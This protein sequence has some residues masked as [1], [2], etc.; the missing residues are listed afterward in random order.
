MHR[1]QPACSRMYSWLLHTYFVFQLNSII[2]DPHTSNIY[3]VNKWVNEW[4][5]N[6]STLFFCFWSYFFVCFPSVF[7]LQPPPSPKT[8]LILWD[9]VQTTLPSCDPIN[10]HS[11]SASEIKESFDGSHMVL[12]LVPYIPVCF[13]FSPLRFSA[14]WKVKPCLL[15]PCNP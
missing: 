2:S 12:I 4:I 1:P 15:H 8:L 13:S 6:K 14:C 3:H 7:Y 11:H 10:C 5:C 9:S